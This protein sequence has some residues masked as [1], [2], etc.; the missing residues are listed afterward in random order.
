MK[1]FAKDESRPQAVNV[2][3]AIQHLKKRDERFKDIEIAYSMLSDFV[4][5]NMASHCAVVEMPREKAAQ[6]E[7]VVAL[8]PGA[9]RCE[10]FMVITLP[11]AAL[12]LGNFVDLLPTLGNL[13]KGWLELID[14]HQQITID[15][16]A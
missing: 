2:L 15:F 5:P 13:I 14:R 3:T 4:H 8:N 12:A 16:N 9:Q 1:T 10:F 11:W 6:H 7:C